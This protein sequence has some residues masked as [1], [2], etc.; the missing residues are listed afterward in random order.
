MTST[1]TDDHALEGLDESALDRKLQ[2]PPPPPQVP[3]APGPQTTGGA[4]T[5]KQADDAMKAKLAVEALRKMNQAHKYFK[6]YKEEKTRLERRAIVS[7]L[8]GGAFFALFAGGAGR[9]MYKAWKLTQI[10]PEDE[11]GLMTEERNAHAAELAS[12][13][14]A[15]YSPED[16]KAYFSGPKDEMPLHGDREPLPTAALP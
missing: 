11:V 14:A 5:G 16:K 12:E 8:V 1:Y 13:H 7:Y 4:G 9:Y 3:L 10:A 6:A 15:R 2:A